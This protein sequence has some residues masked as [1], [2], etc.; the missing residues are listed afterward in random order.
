[1][2]EPRSNRGGASVCETHE[3]GNAYIQYGGYERKG[4]KRMARIRFGVRGP[5]PSSG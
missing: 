1:M 2:D 5:G 4:S 3:L